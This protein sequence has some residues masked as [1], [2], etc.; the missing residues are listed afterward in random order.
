MTAAPSAAS[1]P[2]ARN[3]PLVSLAVLQTALF[4]VPMVVLGQ[5]IGWPASLRL[6]ASEALPLIAREAFAVQ[7]G[8]WAYLL[9]SLALLPLAVSLR[10]YAIERGVSGALVD[11][12]AFC[13]AAA[14]VFKMLGI[15]RWLV[16]MPA[17][18]QLHGSASQAN[19]AVIETVYVALNGYAGAVGEL[20]GVQLVSGVWL[21]LTGLILIRLAF[22]W[23]GRA[24]IVIGAL[25]V[26]TCLRTF[27]PE[28]GAL[29]GIVVPLALL[30]FP[31]LAVMIWRRG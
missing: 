1:L 2:R 8:Y 27:V 19:R 4:L 14:A 12:A 5:A 26:A 23:L 30:W 11:T 20:L 25:F 17:L 22:P 29:Q 7:I 13:G 15:V 9:V 3:L 16:A 24:A 31:A 18:A 6:P 21:V 28:V 10:N